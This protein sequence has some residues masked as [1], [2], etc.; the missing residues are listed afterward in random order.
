MRHLAYVAMLAFC[1]VGSLPLERVFRLGVLRQARRLSLALL[2]GAGP[3]LVWD[4]LATHAG[5]W[6]FDPEQTLP[7]RVL[8]V[9]LEEVAF[10][11]VVP[12]AGILTLEGV[13]VA[14]A[15]LHRERA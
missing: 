11:V 6:W 13:R 2:L 1:A 7:A 5:H 8:G 10:F 12:T 14:L 4:L 15:W 3:F 9:P